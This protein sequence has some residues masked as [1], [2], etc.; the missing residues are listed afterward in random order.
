MA[1]Y[2]WHSSPSA[3]T[4]TAKFNLNAYKDKQDI[5]NAISFFKNGGRTN[6]QAALRMAKNDMLRP[7]KGDR[8]N[9]PNVIIVLTDGGSN[10]EVSNTKPM[11]DNLKNSNT[12]VHV[13]GIGPQINLPE[14]KMIASEDIVPYV[15]IVE[16]ESQVP[17]KAAIL[18]NHLCV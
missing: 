17:E 13:F 5:M 4:A 1:R 14:V 10:M 9:V 18:L 3:D 12:K 6:T 8:S 16:R 15:L 11:A 7:E 2:R